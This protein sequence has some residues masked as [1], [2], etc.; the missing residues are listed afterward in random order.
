MKFQKYTWNIN[1]FITYKVFKIFYSK[2]IA[3]WKNKNI[4]FA[5]VKS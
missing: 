3:N 4:H 2:L 1:A 5:L